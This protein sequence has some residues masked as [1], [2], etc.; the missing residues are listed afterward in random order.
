MQ[1]KKLILIIIATFLLSALSLAYVEHGLRDENLGK[2][3]WQVYFNEP[4]GSSLDFIIENHAEKENFSWEV[5]ADQSK[6]TG[7]TIIVKKGEQK[8]LTLDLGDLRDKKILIIVSEGQ[9][10]KEIYKNL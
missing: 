9:D 2:N 8:K 6:V 7:N 5:M 3:W 1:S 10:K 4:N